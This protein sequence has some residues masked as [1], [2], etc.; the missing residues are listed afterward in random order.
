MSIDPGFLDELERYARARER[1]VSSQFQGEQETR[2]RGEGL[3]FAD[4]RRYSPGDDT[5]RIDW[6]LFARTEE[7]YVTEYE[8]ER[9]RTLHVLLDT[10]GSMGFAGDEETPTKFEFG[11]KLGLG[12]AYLV[13]RAHDDFR[14]ATFADEPRRIDRGRSSRGE[15]L[16]LIDEL[17]GRTP[18]GEGD[19]GAALEAYTEAISSKSLVLV[20]SDCLAPVDEV[21]RGLG[22]L[23]RNEVVLARVLDPVER[24]LPV[25]GDVLAEDPESTRS[26]RTHVGGRRRDSYQG[27]LQA[28]IDDVADRARTLRMRHRLVETDTDFFDAFGN[29]WLA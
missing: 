29:V 18:E 3:T 4:Y 26:L 16:S 8:A 2:E 23:A 14:F 21:E 12:F 28:H 13:A 6:K 24:D 10:S 25:S 22:A 11:A 5:R 19:F 27:R 9:N 1:N 15:V 7:Y 20:V 17:D